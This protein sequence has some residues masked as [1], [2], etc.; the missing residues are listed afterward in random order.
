MICVF[1]FTI[2]L[3]GESARRSFQGRG[4]AVSSKP[5]LVAKFVASDARDVNG[6][7]TMSVVTPV[8]QFDVDY[9]FDVSLFTPFHRICNNNT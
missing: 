5:I 8:E 1:Q 6:Q 3:S 7:P 2:E 4:F 9:D